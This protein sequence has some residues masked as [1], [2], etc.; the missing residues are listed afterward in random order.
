MKVWQQFI[1]TF[2]GFCAILAVVTVIVLQVAGCPPKGGKGGLGKGGDGG[3]V[4][5]KNYTYSCNV[6]HTYTIIVSHIALSY[7][8]FISPTT[9]KHTSSQSNQEQSQSNSATCNCINE[10]CCPYDPHMIPVMW[11]FVSVTVVAMFAMATLMLCCHYQHD[12]NGKRKTVE[13]QDAVVLN[14]EEE[15][16][17]QQQAR[18]KDKKQKNKTTQTRL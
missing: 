10:D 12:C 15:T 7:P 9:N 2:M 4:S 18:K 3:S 8:L 11:A 17:Q 16:E 13:P 1:C 5:T 6:P 14:M